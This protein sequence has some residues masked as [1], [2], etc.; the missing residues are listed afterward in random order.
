M[1]FEA[2]NIEL[3]V[4]FTLLTLLA[5]SYQMVKYHARIN[6]ALALAGA[7]GVLDGGGCVGCGCRCQCRGRGSWKELDDL[8]MMNNEKRIKIKKELEYQISSLRKQWINFFY[9]WHTFDIYFMKWI[10][11]R[12][13]NIFTFL[14][15]VLLQKVVIFKIFKHFKYFGNVQF[16]KTNKVKVRKWYITMLILQM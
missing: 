12:T 11:T 2:S 14:D 6:Q 8:Y 5:C 3:I 9:I 4:L 13:I 1:D 7:I 16:Q 15:I 10:F